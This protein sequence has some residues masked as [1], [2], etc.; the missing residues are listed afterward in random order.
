MKIWIDLTNSPHVNFFAGLINELRRE[1]DFILTCRPLANTIELLELYGFPYHV[2]GKHYGRNK[3]KKVVGFIVRIWQLF[4]FLRREHI[5]VAI[6]H[7]SYYSPLVAKLLGVRSIY[8]NDNEHAEGNRISFIFA[9]KIMVPEFLEL[10][11]LQKQW[12]KAEKIIYYPGVKEGI[13]LWSYNPNFSCDFKVDDRKNKKVIFIRPEPWMAH[14]YRGKKNFIDELLVQLKD[15][16]KIV[17]L[18]RDKSQEN[19]YKQDQFA[20]ITVLEKSISLADIMENCDLFIGAGGTM[21]RE[22]AVLGIPTLSIYQ[23]QLLKVDEYLIKMGF[24]RHNKK[25]DARFINRF[26]EEVRKEPP[27]TELLNKG[28]QAYDLIKSEVMTLP[29]WAEPSKWTSFRKKLLSLIWKNLY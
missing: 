2:V 26:L 24:M 21:T 8:L 17:L 10:G 5:D 4:V 18:P 1:H 7:S 9:D 12:A 11:K 28:K 13:Y 23:D 15:T 6:S 14:Y 22:S 16:Y 19:Y 29:I 20:G 25:L 3:I 27:N